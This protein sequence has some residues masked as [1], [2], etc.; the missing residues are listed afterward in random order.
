MGS[1]IEIDTGLQTSNPNLIMDWDVV[2]TYDLYEYVV[3][4]KLN[5]TN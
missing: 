3:E 4:S 1:T 5:K 2:C